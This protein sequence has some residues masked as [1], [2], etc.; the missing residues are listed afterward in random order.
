MTRYSIKR[1]SILICGYF[2]Q[3]TPD[4]AKPVFTLNN[5][6][7]ME[8]FVSMDLKCKLRLAGLDQVMRQDDKIVCKYA[9]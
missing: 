6:E 7:T 3:L 2:Y 5:T 8:G 9:K 1:E 4:H